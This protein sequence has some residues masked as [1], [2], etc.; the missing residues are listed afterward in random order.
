MFI[1]LFTSNQHNNEFY[2]KFALFP[3]PV[4]VP[5]LKDEQEIVSSK[6]QF[7]IQTLCLS[8]PFQ[9]IGLPPTTTHPPTASLNVAW[10]WASWP[11][12]QS[13]HDVPRPPVG[14]L[15][16]FSFVFLL[17][18]MQSVI[19][20][21]RPLCLLMFPTLKIFAGRFLWHLI[22]SVSLY[23]WFPIHPW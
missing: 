6:L 15:A 4:P 22:Q 17:G 21:S 10:S 7:K 9:N 1:R 12:I 8:H 13:F 18:T 11:V 14:R 2:Q 20:L 3:S 23:I 19:S 5:Y 16:L